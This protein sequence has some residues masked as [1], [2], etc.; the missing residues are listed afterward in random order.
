METPVIC[1]INPDAP[2]KRQQAVL[3][4]TK[5]ARYYREKNGLPQT[6][7]GAAEQDHCPGPRRETPSSRGHPCA[8]ASAVLGKAGGAIWPNL[9]RA[10]HLATEELKGPAGLDE[11]GVS[12]F[13]TPE[14]IDE[15][16]AAH[17]RHLECIQDPP[18][19]NIE[20]LGLEYLFSQSLGESFCLQ[21]VVND[22]PSPEEKVVHPEQPDPIEAEEAYHSDVEAHG[23]ALDDDLPHIT[24]TTHPGGRLQSKRSSWLS[25]A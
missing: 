22:G 2:A 6:S 5:E 12:L 13:K 19:M 10:S 21:D 16:E 18:D 20:L 25:K 14:A 24:L 11:S 15:M 23:I 17:Q 9:Q 4:A 1:V 8:I 3:V 7:T